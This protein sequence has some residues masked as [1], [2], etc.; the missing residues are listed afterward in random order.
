[1]LCHLGN[2]AYRTNTVVRC[3]PKTDKL[4]DNPAGE[5]L[6][7]RPEYRAGWDIKV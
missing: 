3:D 6:W 4:L 5:K 2:I 7:G 1:M